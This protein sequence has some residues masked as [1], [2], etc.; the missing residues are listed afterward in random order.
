MYGAIAQCMRLLRNVQLHC[1][2]TEVKIDPFEINSDSITQCTGVLR[3]AQV[4]CALCNVIGQ[5]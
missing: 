5:G 3:I 1:A 4:H 2:I